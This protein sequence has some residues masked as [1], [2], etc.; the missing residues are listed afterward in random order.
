MARAILTDREEEILTGEADV[1]DDYYSTVRSSVRHKIRM[2]R[3]DCK[4]LD[5]HDDSLGDMLRDVISGKYEGTTRVE[6]TPE[7]VTKRDK[8]RFEVKTVYQDDDS[9]PYKS[10]E[11]VSHTGIADDKDGSPPA[12]YLNFQKDEKG[13]ST[14]RIVFYDEGPPVYE[15]WCE[16]DGTEFWM[17]FSEAGGLRVQQL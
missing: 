7:E 11:T 14:R 8:L 5:E 6:I 10:V 1:S 9:T 15:R 4:V 2:L 16:R 3:D 12:I 17:R 13:R